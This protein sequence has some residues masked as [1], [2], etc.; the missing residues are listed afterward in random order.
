MPGIDFSNDP[1]LATPN[2][3]RENDPSP[4]LL[5]QDVE[6]LLHGTS[7][8]HDHVEQGHRKGQK[9]G[10][11]E[12]FS[13]R[14]VP[15]EQDTPPCGDRHDIVRLQNGVRR[16]LDELNTSSEPFNKDPLGARGAFEIPDGPAHRGVGQPKA[17]MLHSL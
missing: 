15:L 3:L 10:I 5:G 17:R 2:Q 13:K 12:L 11:L 4:V 7:F 9:L 14:Q 1:L 6:R 8:R 16:G